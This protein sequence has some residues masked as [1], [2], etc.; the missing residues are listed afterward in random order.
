MVVITLDCREIKLQ[1]GIEQIPMS[2]VFGA[3]DDSISSLLG[4]LWWVLSRVLF[5]T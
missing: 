3:R 1:T 4:K 2:E 5:D